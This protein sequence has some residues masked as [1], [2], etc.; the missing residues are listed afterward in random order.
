MGGQLP[1]D[2]LDHVIIL[3]ERHLKRLLSSYLLY[4]HEDR[5][6]VSRA[7]GLG[8]VGEGPGAAQEAICLELGNK[9]GLGY[10][11]WQ[12]GLLAERQSDKQAKRQKL[13]AKPTRMSGF[14]RWGAIP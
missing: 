14:A 1:R 3:N 4:Y 13:R 6:T 11:Y 2:L 8:A 10:C 12:W 5:T 7:S 9:E